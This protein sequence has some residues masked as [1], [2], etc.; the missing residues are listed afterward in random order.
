[1]KAVGIE[2]SPR[3]T[4]L[5]AGWETC[6]LR[7]VQN[8]HC[9]LVK[10]YRL[11]VACEADEDIGYLVRYIGEDNLI[12]G[13]DYGHRDPSEERELVNTMKSRED[14]PAFLTNKILSDNPKS[15]YGL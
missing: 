8:I 9:G 14:I 13:S 10:K 7:Q 3:R 4:K 12:I 15:F 11:Y 5:F 2:R 6:S 1:M